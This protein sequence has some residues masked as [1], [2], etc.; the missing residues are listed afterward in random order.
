MTWRTLPSEILRG[1]RG[2]WKGILAY[3]L[4]IVISLTAFLYLT[5]PWKM[6]E[7]RLLYELSRQTG[8]AFH[9]RQTD[10]TFPLGLRFEGVEMARPTGGPLGRIDRIDLRVSPLD[11]LSGRMTTD[12]SA[13]AFG[14]N[15]SGTFGATSRRQELDTEWRKVDLAGLKTVA[16][17]QIGLAGSLSGKAHVTFLPSETAGALRLS[18]DRA[19]IK[20]LK[21]MGFP[22]P[23]MEF[24]EVRGTAEIKNRVLTLKEVRLRGDDVKGTIKGDITF[25]G[26]TTP[27]S[28]NLK[29]RIHLSDRA[30][31]PYQ[32]FLS[33]IEKNRD[34]E[35][36]YPF[37]LQGTFKEP[38][39]SL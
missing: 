19:R 38:K 12:I 15:A 4:L 36:Y 20:D 31:A 33:L 29:F 27:A 39:I 24:E 18:V 34:K 37:T 23:E 1:I 25:G 32:G 26:G 7:D 35:G 14:G 10:H 21:V 9:P 11:F 13:E 16:G 6:L 22:L 3:G 8:L 17:L 5:F 2:R 30:R 28:L